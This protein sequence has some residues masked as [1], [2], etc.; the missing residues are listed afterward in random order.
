MAIPSPSPDL[1]MRSSSRLLSI[2]ACLVVSFIAQAAPAQDDDVFD[3][4]E[5][6]A[7]L[8]LPQP[9]NAFRSGGGVPGP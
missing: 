7:P 3:P 9:P 4:R 6:F 5:L 2:L 1:P 8:Q